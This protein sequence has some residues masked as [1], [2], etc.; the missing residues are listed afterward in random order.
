MQSNSLTTRASTQLSASSSALS[1][2]LQDWQKGYRSLPQEHDY[3]L[4]E[5]AG[6]IPHELNGTLFRNGPGLLDING[7]RIHHPFD[8]DGMVCAITF[9]DGRV[10]FR[11]RFVRTQ[12]YL[13]EQQ[14]G[15]ILYRGVFGTQKSGG[16]LANAFDLRLKNIANTN[17]IYW[18]GKLLALWEAAQPHRLDPQTLE[19]IGLDDLEGAL[20]PG[21]SFSAHPRIDPACSLEEGKPCLVNFAVK[22][23]LSSTLTIRELNG[24]GKVVRQHAHTIPGFA[25]MHDF[26]ITPNYCIFFQAPVRFSPIPYLLGWKG[27]GQC[28]QVRQDQPTQ[29]ILIPRHGDGS[30]RIIPVEAGFVFHHVNAFEQAGSLYVD[31]LCYASLPKIDPDQDYLHVKFSALDPAQLYRFQVNLLTGAV[32][33]QLIAPRCCEFPTLHPNLVGHTYR[34][35]YLAAA[36]AP[37]GNAPLQAILKHDWQTGERYLWSAA[38]RGFVGEP[39]FVPRPNGSAEDDG[40]VLVLVFNAERERS[41]VVILDAR[42]LDVAARLELKHHVPY[43]LHGHFTPHCFMC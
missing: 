7:Q 9:Q 35:A 42:T 29:L 32:D 27:A 41:E 2:D 37:T 18:G 6:E 28:L 33:R 13:E 43:G 4:D 10:H 36:H 5:I 39:V 17:V 26:A 19:T 1:Y 3:W 11:N 12:G 22:T 25:F 23:G 40:W 30:V 20:Q 21:D 15:K 31:S 8:G 24:S 16:W 34:Y 14:A 38:P